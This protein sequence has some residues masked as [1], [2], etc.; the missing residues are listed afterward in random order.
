MGNA[1]GDIK[2]MADEV[3]LTNDE[4]GVAH[5]LHQLIEQQVKPV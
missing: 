1:R 4:N 3:T 5:I 2:E